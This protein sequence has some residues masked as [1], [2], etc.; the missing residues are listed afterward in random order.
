MRAAHEDVRF[1]SYR[2]SMPDLPSCFL[3]EN[4]S[5]NEIQIPEKKIIVSINIQFP[6]VADATQQLNLLGTLAGSKNP[7]SLCADLM[8]REVG[9][10]AKPA[11]GS[12]PT[13]S[14]LTRDNSY[15]VAYIH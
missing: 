2:P 6:S 1:A 8:E 10:Y 7:A 15:N 14:Y 3:E 11:Q 4:L 5:R 9:E 12:Q 13:S